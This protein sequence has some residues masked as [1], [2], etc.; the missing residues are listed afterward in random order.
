[1]DSPP[2]HPSLA[3]KPSSLLRFPSPPDWPVP[4]SGSFG[5]FSGQP[6]S[7]IAQPWPWARGDEGGLLPYS[8]PAQ[9]LGRK[10]CHGQKVPMAESLLPKLGGGFPQDCSQTLPGKEQKAR[11]G[12]PLPLSAMECLPWL[13]PGS[14]WR[15]W[16]WALRGVGVGC[17]ILLCLLSSNAGGLPRGPLRMLG[18]GERAFGK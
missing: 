2:P 10:S 3:P 9:C 5:A 17:W 8:C 11:P 13:G 4:G 7:S 1:M 15:P 16:A 14:A 6:L 12:C 18:G